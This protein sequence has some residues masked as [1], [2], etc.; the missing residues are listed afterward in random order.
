MVFSLDRILFFGQNRIGSEL[1][2]WQKSVYRSIF[3]K[4]HRIGFRGLVLVIGAG[5]SGMSTLAA[6]KK[7]Q[8]EGTEIP[9]IVCFEK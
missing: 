7:L 6:F 4:N 3:V 5:P 8:D 9:E 2:F 1:F